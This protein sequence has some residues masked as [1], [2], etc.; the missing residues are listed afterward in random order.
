MLVA[1]VVEDLEGEVILVRGVSGWR[2]VGGDERGEGRRR[3][4]DRRHG[5]YTLS[6]LVSTCGVTRSNKDVQA[7]SR[8]Y[9]EEFIRCVKRGRC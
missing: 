1:K 3:R 9:R 2:R 7:R 6:R 8:C 5:K 4:Y